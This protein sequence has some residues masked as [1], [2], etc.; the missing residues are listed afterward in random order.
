MN[1][2]ELLDYLKVTFS[3]LISETGIEAKDS[4]RGFKYAIDATYRAIGVPAASL[5]IADS[6]LG[7]FAAGIDPNEATFAIARLFA[8]R[9]FSYLLSVNTDIQIDNLRTSQSQMFD[10]VIV[11][12]KEAESQVERMG[13]SELTTSKKF[14]LAK[15][16]LDY[17][18]P[19]SAVDEMG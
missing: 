9:R 1:R 15:I 17:L 10:Q 4:P 19:A 16:R 7:T 14:R 6:S 11:L 8:L 3:T 18:Q 2:A 12:I 13:Y 5:N